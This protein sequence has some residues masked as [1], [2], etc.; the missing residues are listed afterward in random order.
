MIQVK[1]AQTKSEKKRLARQLKAVLGIKAKP[2][3]KT[4]LNVNKQKQKSKKAKVSAPNNLV[5]VAAIQAGKQ[6][7][8]TDHLVQ[9]LFYPN[10]GIFRGLC[11]GSSQTSLC[12]IKT[13]FDMPITAGSSFAMAWQP[14]S[15]TATNSISYYSNASP[16]FDPYNAGATTV[17]GPFVTTNPSLSYRV[18][19]ARLIFVP[20]QTLLNNGGE[21]SFSYFG[22]SA[23][24]ATANWT[25]A[26]ADEQDWTLPVSPVKSYILNWVPNQLEVDFITSGNAYSTVSAFYFY[27]VPPVATG[28]SYRVDFQVSVEYMPTATYRPFVIREPPLTPLSSYDD[29]NRSLISSWDSSVMCCYDKWMNQ[30]ALRQ[31]KLGG[32]EIVEKMYKSGSG[33]L[34]TGQRI[35]LKGLER[36]GPK[37]GLLG[38]D[39][40]DD[41]GIPDAV[42]APFDYM[43]GR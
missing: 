37:L 24:T 40:L 35:G 10:Q 18:V 29:L 41:N 42:Q 1:S 32:H 28:M 36:F 9:T 43:L 4:K 22:N 14:T 12:T 7:I 13:S 23:G 20:S 5:Q 38:L 15:L 31:R 16:I 30:D 19:S 11:K 3:R 2:I 8:D 6:L 27:F 39:D 17:P 26:I 34:R 25:R 33:A 21:G